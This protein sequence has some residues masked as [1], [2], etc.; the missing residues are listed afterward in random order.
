MK[1]KVLFKVLFFLL[2]ITLSLNVLKAQTTL[3][4]FKRADSMSKNTERVYSVNIQPAWVQ[5]AHIFWYINPTAKGNEFMMVDPEKGTKAPAFDQEKLAT[6][7]TEVTGKKVNSNKLPITRVNFSKDSKTIDFIIDSTKWN[8]II[9]DNTLTKGEQTRNPRQNNG[10]WGADREGQRQG[11]P[12]T[13]PDKKYEAFI[14]NFNVFIREVSSKVE[15]QL[16]TDG[17]ESDYYAPRMS[18]SPDSKKLMTTKTIANKKHIIYFVQSS[19]T[20]QL[21]PKLE[22]REY[23]KPGDA[24]PIKR[25]VLFNI[26]QKKQIAINT[27]PFENQY[28]LDLTGWRRDSKSFTFE[29]NQRGHQVYQV[30]SVDAE[31]GETKIIIDEQYK[32]FFDYSTKKYRFDVN[33]GKEIIWASERDGW[34]HLYLFDGKTG[35]IK[36]QITRGEW[37]VREVVNVD[38]VARQI[39]FKGAGKVPGQDPYLIHYYRVNFDGSQLVDLT[40]EDANH[41]AV[42]SSDWK[43]FVDS[44]SRVDLPT[45]HVLRQ[46]TDGKIIQEIEKA[47]IKTL[48]KTGWKMPEVFTSK[49]RDGKT[50]IWGIIMRPTNFDPSKKYPIIEYIYAGPQGSFVPKTFAAYNGNMS[51]LAELG[52]I[53]VQIDGMG[54]NFRSKAFHDVCWKNLKD[55]GFPDRILWITAAAKKYPYMDLTRVGIHGT[56]A[57]GQNA[58]GAVLFHPEFYKVSVSSCG[59]HD[60]RM[61][62]LWWNE[63]WMGYPIG[64]QYDSCSNVTNAFRLKGKLLLMVG[65]VDDNVDPASTMQVVNALIKSNK[66][67]DFLVLP[68]SNHTSGGKYG[69]RRRRDFFVKNLLGYETPDWNKIDN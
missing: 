47:D 54:T 39:I 46:T 56:S 52:F 32:T 51:A 59:C 64:P 67:F 62:K 28:E 38:T 3:A 17:T 61:D 43:Y 14:K 13:S 5:D 11:R 25:P 4:D 24:V 27:T 68:G 9:A 12:S 55:A 53:V 36:I 33:D 35:A 57:G 30:V 10:Y 15:T 63:A 41:A 18:W 49:G 19:P 65:E 31:T 58:M 22:S 34:N 6:K 50:D 66:D 60:N 29:F 69:E 23:L 20:D 26:E 2:G 42:F 45:T 8:Y 37:L 48:L 21:Q 44:Y 40:P 16:S 7:I 1:I